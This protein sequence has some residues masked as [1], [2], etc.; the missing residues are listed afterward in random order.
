MKTMMNRIFLILIF[1]VLI[2][3]IYN[4]FITDSFSLS[5]IN[6][7]LYN[8]T[9]NKLFIEASYAAKLLNS[10]YIFVDVRDEWDFKE[11]HITGSINVPFYKIVEKKD[12]FNN[13][14]KEAR[15][16]VYCSDLSCELSEK[17]HDFLFN[18]GFN[19]VQIL[20]D[21]FNIWKKLN[22]PI[23]KGIN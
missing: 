7:E 9:E 15:L 16:I 8:V 20:K 1:S 3:F 6:S 5:S 23:S 19:N 4:K 22:L 18:L 13:F 10:D 14:N 12:I 21:G 11:A 2:G 17:S